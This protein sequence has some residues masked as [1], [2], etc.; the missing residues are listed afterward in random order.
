[1][2]RQ[3]PA[4]LGYLDANGR[5][6]LCWPNDDGDPFDDAT[7][8]LYVNVHTDNNHW[9]VQRTGSWDPFGGSSTR[10]RR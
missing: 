5:A 8:E 10:L 3:R 6:T 9:K 4:E 2:E 7:Q 1:M